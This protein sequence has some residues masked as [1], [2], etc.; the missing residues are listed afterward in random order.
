MKNR[1]A[2]KKI[3]GRK[4]KS[5]PTRLDKPPDPAMS[6]RT[7][8]VMG[9]MPA[10]SSISTMEAPASFREDS[11]S[12]VTVVTVS[13]SPLTSMASTSPPIV[14]AIT[15]LT[16][17]SLEFPNA[18]EKSVKTIA[19][20][21]TTIN[22]YTRL[23]RI[24]RPSMLDASR[25]PRPTESAQQFESLAPPLPAGTLPREQSTISISDR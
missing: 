2:P 15:S 7:L 25:L 5:I 19:V 22:K 6:I 18:S 13:V 24:S 17:T 9:S 10:R 21:A 3:S 23:L 16:D 11:T 4:L 14:S 1:I 20:M 8:V 12:P